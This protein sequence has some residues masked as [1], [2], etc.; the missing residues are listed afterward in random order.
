MPFKFNKQNG[1]W[2]TNNK[3]LY[4]ELKNL[5]K[6]WQKYIPEYVKNLSSRQLKIF[7]NALIC[8]F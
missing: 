4:T 3:K 8:Y 7:F 2:T 1:I 6:C 5:G